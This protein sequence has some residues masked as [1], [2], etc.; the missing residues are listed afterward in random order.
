MT[1]PST[2]VVWSPQTEAD[3]IEIWLYGAREHSPSDAD[4]HL[5]DIYV[6]CTRL[7]DWP[8]SGRARSEII[9]GLRSLSVPPHVVFYRVTGSTVEIVRVLHGRRDIEVI[10]ADE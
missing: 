10:F 2:T 1:K 5:R 6:S 4:Q 3:L 8:Y 7:G 9:P